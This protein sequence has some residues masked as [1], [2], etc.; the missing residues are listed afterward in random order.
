VPITRCQGPSLAHAKRLFT[1]RAGA[2]SCTPCAPSRHRASAAD[3]SS[4]SHR[5]GL[6]RIPDRR[7]SQPGA[8]DGDLEESGARAQCR[9]GQPQH[10]SPRI[11]IPAVVRHRART[12]GSIAVGPLPLF[13]LL[14]RG[15]F[16][17]A[18]ERLASPEPRL[19]HPNRRSLPSGPGPD[20]TVAMTEAVS[21]K[22]PTLPLQKRGRRGL[23][24]CRTSSAL[25]AFCSDP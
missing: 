22:I 10:S 9:L 6:R 16:T 14:A 15:V 18:F 23:R 24:C 13:H 17:W 7:R 2:G 8:N 11:N 4:G 5:S 12:I 3:R 20:Y 1:H 21:P 19:R 25:R